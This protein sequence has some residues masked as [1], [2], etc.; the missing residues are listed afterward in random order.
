M[1]VEGWLAPPSGAAVA[2]DKYREFYLNTIRI[3][4]E[5]F[6]GVLLRGCFMLISAFQHINIRCVDMDQTRDFYRAV[7]GLEVGE[8]PPFDSKGYWLYL[9]EDPIVHLVQKPPGEAS[10]GPGTG[11]L[12]HIAFVGENLSAFKGNLQRAQVSFF[13][14]DVPGRAIRQVFLQDPNGV[15]LEIS[16]NI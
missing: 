10:G 2:D 7:L 14:R 11:N 9:G 4:A 15:T 13:E 6:S 1:D 12:D 8:R 5:H 16:F 3:L